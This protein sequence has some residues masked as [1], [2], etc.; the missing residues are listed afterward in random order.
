MRPCPRGR[1]YKGWEQ[2]APVMEAPG[3]SVTA[4]AISQ[5]IVNEVFFSS[6]VGVGACLRGSC[7]NVH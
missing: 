1:S 3:L 4:A 2:T 7:G 5:F 6:F